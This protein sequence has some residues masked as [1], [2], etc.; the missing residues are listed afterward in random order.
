M[1]STTRF[2]FLNHEYTNG[3][4]FRP[5]KTRLIYYFH[6]RYNNVSTIWVTTTN[7]CSIDPSHIFLFENYL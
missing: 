2:L 7:N 4:I 1:L 6:V 5:I 3:L